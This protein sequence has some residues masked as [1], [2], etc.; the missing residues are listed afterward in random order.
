MV[1]KKIPDEFLKLK[2]II[3]KLM[4]S[5]KPINEKTNIDPDFRIK[6]QKTT[7]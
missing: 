4:S 3:G 2:E 1:T 7:E 5:I 6:N